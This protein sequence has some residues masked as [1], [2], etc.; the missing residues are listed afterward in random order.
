MD[1]EARERKRAYNR[2]YGRRWYAE[3]KEHKREYRK[4][5]RE[6]INAQQR[7][8]YAR[9]KEHHLGMVTKRKKEKYGGRC[10]VC[11]KETYSHTKSKLAPRF[12]SDHVKELW[13]EK[14]GK[15]VFPKS[16]EDPA[17]FTEATRDDPKSSR[18]Y[19][20]KIRQDQQAA[21]SR[22]SPSFSRLT[23]SEGR[24]RVWKSGNPPTDRTEGDS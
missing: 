6:R 13:E 4:R 10:V 19:A 1:D 14:L 12:C 15:R 23:R 20:A 17:P 7:E 11:G 2:E 22:A 18:Q 24:V 8:W 9:N 5:N 16:Y 21:A 3:H